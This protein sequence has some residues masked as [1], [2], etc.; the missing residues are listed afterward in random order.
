MK[1]EDLIAAGAIIVNPDERVKKSVKWTGEV[2]GKS[3]KLEFDIHVKREMSAADFEYMVVQSSEPDV[4]RMARRV[5][6]MVTLGDQGEQSIPYDVAREMKPSLL[7][8]FVEQINLVE[9]DNAPKE[10]VKTD[11]DSKGETEKN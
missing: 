3:A 10:D 1:L 2:N 9:K 4:V 7:I 5:S 11:S 8:A 6:R